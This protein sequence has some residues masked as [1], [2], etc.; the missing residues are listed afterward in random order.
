MGAVLLNCVKGRAAL[1]G[2]RKFTIDL[3]P[4]RIGVSAGQDEAIELAK[5]YGYESVEPFG[6]HLAGLGD[7]AKEVAAKVKDSGLVWGA[8][9]MP[10]DFR[11][12]EA[13]FK[14]DL[15]QLPGICKGLQ[16][17]GVTRVGTWLKPNHEELS[18]L[19]N[20]RL[21]A[22][23][24]RQIAK[25]LGDY[26]LRFGLEYVGPRTLWSAARYPFVHSMVETRELLAE[27]NCENVGLVLDS[28]HWYTA[29]ED[30][31]ALLSLTNKDVVAV[32]LN[33]APAGIDVRDQIDNRR[34]LPA[35]TGV[36]DVQTFLR[37]LVKI[38]YDGPVRAEPFNQP[39]NALGNAEAS[40]KTADAIRKAVSTLR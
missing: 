23:R 8:A 34:E 6:G 21:H 36:I 35:A 40:E 11:G 32:D 5:K 10:T 38:G 9:G 13:K 25:V 22:T 15:K 4:G 19:A 17:A 26:G 37:A 29:E 20:F 16:L 7:G 30:E 24:L 33:D 28:W 12:D 14:R 31:A 2:E 1:A 27:I 3:C 18:Y 39:L